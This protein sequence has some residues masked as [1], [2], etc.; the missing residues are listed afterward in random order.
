MSLPKELNLGSNK[1]MAASSRPQILRFRSDN[2]SYTA[3]DTIRIEIPTNRQGH[4]IFPQESFLEFRY[5]VNG[6]GGAGVGATN[7]YLDQSAYSFFNR[8]R[9]LHG[10]TVI[11]DTLYANKLWTALYDIQVNEAERKQDTITKGV[12]DPTALNATSTYN[13]GL[14]GHLA[15]TRASAAAAADSTLFEIN[16][17]IPSAV[18]GS[19]ASKALPISLLGASSLYLELELAPL[20]QVFVQQLAAATSNGTLNS[21]TIQDIYFNAKTA[22][23]P[24]DVEQALIASTGGVVNLPAV[25]YKCE[26]K[27]IAAT[28]TSFSD[29]FS[30]QYSSLKNFLFFPQNQQSSNGT[31]ASRSVSSRSRAYINEYY[32]NINGEVFPSQ[33]ITGYARQYSELLRSFDMLTDTNAGGILTFSN[34]TVNTSTTASDILDTVGDT[35]WLTSADQKRWIGGIDL[36]RFNRSSDV[37]MSGTST[38]GQLLSLVINFSQNPDEALT[39]YGACM[40]DVLYHIENGQMVA[41][42]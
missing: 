13:S 22:I 24:I 1:P 3:G 5:K 7:W 39:L 8:L 23:L 18:F 29:K 27:A 11:E 17:V 16:M 14:F 20:N 34:Y 26:S 9:V 21:Y 15:L 35:T 28:A 19:L 36:D 40:Y 30:F 4:Y 37:L 2:S 6:T 25:A 12:Y 41:K 38:I 31:I 42:F 32:L 10:S 33:S